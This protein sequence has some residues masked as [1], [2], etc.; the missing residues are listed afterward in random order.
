MDLDPNLLALAKA[1]A[2]LFTAGQA[3]Q[4]GLSRTWLRELVRV[5]TVLHPAR[6]LYA[7]CSLVDTSPVAWHLTLARGAHLLYD[8]A[9]LTGVTAVLARRLPVGNCR[10]DRPDLRRP[11]THQVG[12][13]RAGPGPCWS[14]STRPASPWQRAEPASSS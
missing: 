10:L 8:D 4:A 14:S 6:G 1:Q 3:H 12:L 5:W 7:V 9:Q 13:A 11:I 2:G